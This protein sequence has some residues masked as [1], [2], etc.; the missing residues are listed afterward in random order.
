MRD[1]D[2]QLG[3]SLR[4]R[5]QV[6]GI[7]IGFLFVLGLLAWLA[8][9]YATPAAI[10]D[11]I[12]EFFR[13]GRIRGALAACITLVFYVLGLPIGLVLALLSVIQGS[14]GRRTWLT[15]W[16][17]REL[18]Q[19]RAG[20]RGEQQAALPGTE[21]ESPALEQALEGRLPP[22]VGWGVLLISR[23]SIGPGAAAVVGDWGCSTVFM[24][25]TRR[26][27]LCTLNR[28]R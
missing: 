18:S 24:D 1:H 9:S 3:L 4:Q 13:T 8:I 21:G 10:L 5:C 17:L 27:I 19:R 6:V 20:K 16:I 14:L 12:P 26:V 11:S 23:R 22:F 2:D 15:R 28:A 7:G 25:A